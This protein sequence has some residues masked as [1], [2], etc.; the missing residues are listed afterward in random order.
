MNKLKQLI[1][2]VQTPPSA[3]LKLK[4]QRNPEKLEKRHNSEKAKT[5]SLKGAKLVCHDFCCEFAIG[6][7][8][9][10][11]SKHVHNVALKRLKITSTE[12]PD[13]SRQTAS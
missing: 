11:V 2:K 13:R 7:L 3:S 6:K 9:R 8:P 10:N 1:Q 4:F 12:A 5:K